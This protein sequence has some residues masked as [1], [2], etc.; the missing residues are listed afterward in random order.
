MGYRSIQATTSI[1]KRPT[2]LR[3]N[4][5]VLGPDYCGDS[6]VKLSTTNGLAV[7]DYFTPYNQENR[8]APTKT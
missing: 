3:Q 4:N 8:R 5:N 1:L 7:G 2:V 6:F